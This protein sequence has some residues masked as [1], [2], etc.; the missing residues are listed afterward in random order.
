[1]PTIL[2]TT[3]ALAISAILTRPLPKTMALGGVAT[4]IMK[5]HDAERVAGI[6]SIKGFT[7][8]AK[9]TE[10]RIGKIISV[11][12]VFEVNSVRKVN[13]KHIESIMIIGE[14]PAKPANSLPMR[15]ESPVT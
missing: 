5:A 6:M 4:G 9:P 14:V 7:C 12:A 13:P 3:P 1:M 2:I 10:A 8:M 15:A 11:V